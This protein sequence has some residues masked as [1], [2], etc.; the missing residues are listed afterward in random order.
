VELD[1]TDEGKGLPPG[2]LEWDGG[3]AENLSIGI[4]GMRARASRLG[5]QMSIGSGPDGTTLHVAI[6]ITAAA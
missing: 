1:L 5:G 4:A 2:T 3:S 6:P